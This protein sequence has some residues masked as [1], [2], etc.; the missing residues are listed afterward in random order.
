MTLI[1]K[2]S[3]IFYL[4]RKKYDKSEGKSLFCFLRLSFKIKEMK[5]RV[6]EICG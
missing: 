6:E 4:Q 3:V 1:G 5:L 2:I